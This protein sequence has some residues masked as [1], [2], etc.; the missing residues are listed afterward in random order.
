M[1]VSWPRRPGYGPRRPG[2]GPRRLLEEGQISSRGRG[3]GFG[4]LLA[5][6]W[7]WVLEVWVWAPEAFVLAREVWA[8][9]PWASEA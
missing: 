7:V 9:E 5:E 2:F 4:R 1:P 6:A 3:L 8:L